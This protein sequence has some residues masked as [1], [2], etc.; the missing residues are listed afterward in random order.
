MTRLPLDHDPFEPQLVTI[1]DS[2]L[3]ED[4]LDNLSMWL[5]QEPFD[6]FEHLDCQF[7]YGGDN[8][9]I[10][11]RLAAPMAEDRLT[12]LAAGIDKALSRIVRDV[13]FAT[14]RYAATRHGR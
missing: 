9:R 4:R 3:E 5:W 14:S 1:F 11:C 2:P 6:G 7:E 8:D 12:I 10:F 13:G